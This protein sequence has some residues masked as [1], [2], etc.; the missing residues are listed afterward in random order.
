MFFCRAVVIKLQFRLTSVKCISFHKAVI[1]VRL[2]I[3]LLTLFNF[4]I[5]RNGRYDIMSCMISDGISV[6]PVVLVG[7][8]SVFVDCW[9]MPV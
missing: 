1:M 4:I 8:D 2:F 7:L 9:L 3:L 6:R 5:C